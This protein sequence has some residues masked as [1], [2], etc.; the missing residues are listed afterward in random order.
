[1]VA[2]KLRYEDLSVSALKSIISYVFQS[3]KQTGASKHNTTK[4]ACLEF[5]ATVD[6]IK[7]N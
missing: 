5:L 1:M 4:A 7:L 3:Q 6:A 2:E